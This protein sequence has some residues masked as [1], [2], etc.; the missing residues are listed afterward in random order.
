MVLVMTSGADAS[1]RRMTMQH[2]TTDQGRAPDIDWDLVE[3]SLCAFAP[4][5]K[6]ILLV[7]D[8]TYRRAA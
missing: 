7:V 5:A 1:E 2:L 8:M 6:L 3:L 4:F